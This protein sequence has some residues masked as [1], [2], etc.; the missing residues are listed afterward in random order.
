MC[1]IKTAKNSGW[2]SF[3]TKASN[4]YGTH[5][6]A[7]SRKAIKPTELIAL[8]SHNPSG[9]HLKI[10]QDILEKIFPHPA[11]SN[12]STYIPP[13]TPYDCPFTKG[14]VANDTHHLSKRKAPAPDGNDN[15]M[16]QQIFKKFPFLLIERFNTRL[17][18]AKCPD[19]LKVGNIILF[20]KHGKSK[21]EYIFLPAHLSAPYNR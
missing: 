17:K 10:A 8:N 20:H 14:E 7:G 19:P 5:Y 13:S 3:C 16:I 2:K 21:T 15:I 6:K 4:P 18:L 9:K 12:S 11:N 1:K